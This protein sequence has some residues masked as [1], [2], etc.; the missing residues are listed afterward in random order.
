MAQKINDQLVGATIAGAVISDDGE[1][2]GLKVFK[3][4]TNKEVTVIWVDRDSEGNGPGWLAWP[5]N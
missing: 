4:G 1:S 2:F 5:A 3:H